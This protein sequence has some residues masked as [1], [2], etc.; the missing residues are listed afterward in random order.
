LG[1]YNLKMFDN[2][3]TVD[4]DTSLKKYPYNKYYNED[5]MNKLAKRV[6]KNKTIDN[7]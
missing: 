7:S 4:F 2:G 6:F 3:Y 5:E 1:R